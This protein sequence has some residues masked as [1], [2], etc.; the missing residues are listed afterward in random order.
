MHDRYWED[1]IGRRGWESFRGR[2]H[3]WRVSTLNPTGPY[4]LESYLIPLAHA[5]IMTFTK[6]GFLIGTHGM[7]GPLATFS[8]AFRSLPAK[9]FATLEGVPAPLVVRTLEHDNTRYLYVVNPS[10]EAADLTLPLG[11]KEKTVRDLGTGT[12]VLPGKN[13][14]VRMTPMSFKAYRIDKE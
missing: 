9:P 5:D 7:E 11:D 10:Q 13:L 2:E 6:G 3:G 12:S 14:T 8:R 4:A 1:S